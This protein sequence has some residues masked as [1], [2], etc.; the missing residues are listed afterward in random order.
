MRHLNYNHLLYFWTVAQ[1][2]S[3]ARAAEALHLAPQTISGQLKMLEESIGEP[4]FSRV[5][6]GLAITDTGRIVEQYADEIFNLGSELT[7]RIKGKALGAPLNL[8]VGIVNSIPKL[9]AYRILKPAMGLEPLMKI[10]CYEDGL[11]SLLADLSIHKLDLVLSDRPIPSALNVR[12]YNHELGAS[13]LSFFGA[14]ELIAKHSGDFPA[15]LNEAPVLLPVKGHALR[16]NLADWF[17][18]KSLTPRIVADFDDSALM[19][20]FGE[21]GEGFFPAPTVM[22]R[23]VESIFGVKH[24]GVIEGV[25]EHFYLVSPERKIKHP[26]VLE[27]TDAA[28]SNLREF[29]Q[30]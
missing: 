14:P 8:N 29:A 23:Q 24:L 22:R 19:K 25:M 13:A 2:G 17:E 9:I 12:A 28:R 16:R 30:A 1:E 11:D 15:C 4:L 5:G 7:Q 6:R 3:V 20:V 26:A 18:T 21:A 10:S 27:I